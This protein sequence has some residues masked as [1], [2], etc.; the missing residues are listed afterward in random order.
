MSKLTDLSEN[1][2]LLFLD[3]LTELSKR[4]KIKI[5]SYDWT[6]DPPLV[7]TRV[8]TPGEYVLCD[9]F[10]NSLSNDAQ[11][12]LFEHLQQQ[13]QQPLFCF[14]DAHEREAPLFDF[15]NVECA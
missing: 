6:I 2:I 8:D 13:Q 7:L 14:V 4:F 10:G 1:E 5:C 3:E 12:T 11:A 15:S 9:A